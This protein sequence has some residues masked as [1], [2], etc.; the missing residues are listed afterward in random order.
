M[1]FVS[2]VAS[3]ITVGAAETDAEIYL[4]KLKTVIHFSTAIRTKYMSKV[5]QQFMFDRKLYL[6][7]LKLRVSNNIVS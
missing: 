4:C 7:H 6:Q 3:M 5:W 1:C 2:L